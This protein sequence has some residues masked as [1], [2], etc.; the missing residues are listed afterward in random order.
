VALSRDSKD[1]PGYRALVRHLHKIYTPPAMDMEQQKRQALSYMQRH[2]RFYMQRHDALNLRPCGTST[3]SSKRIATSALHAAESNV[4][5]RRSLDVLDADKRSETLCST[6]G[7]SEDSQSRGAKHTATSV[8]TSAIR[9]A[10]PI[11]AQTS[12]VQARVKSLATRVNNQHAEASRCAMHTTKLHMDLY[13]KRD[14]GHTQA[15]R[16]PH[17]GASQ[18]VICPETRRATLIRI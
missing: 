11:A 6:Q 9:S 13:A 5:P 8:V 2:A 17:A 3:Q 12:P 16:R 4:A 1:R 18:D 7:S 14:A 15:T 10:I